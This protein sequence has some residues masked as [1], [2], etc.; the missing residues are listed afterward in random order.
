MATTVNMHE[1]KSTLSRLVELVAMGDE[2]EIIIARNGRP[3][4]KL[5]PIDSAKPAEQRIG[6]A[7]GMLS[8]PE[9]IDLTND[10]I[11]EL[12]LGEAP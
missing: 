9:S 2:K 1:A 8:V 4:A 5:M 6:V 12:F 10:R 11:A 7:K 3:V